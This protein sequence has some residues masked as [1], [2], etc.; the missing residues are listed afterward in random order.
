MNEN[1]DNEMKESRG[2]IADDIG[3]ASKDENHRRPK[4]SFAFKPQKKILIGGAG[5]LLLIILIALFSG[6][7]DELPPQDFRLNQLEEKITRLEGIRDTIVFLEKQGEELQQ[8]VAEARKSARSLTL[9]LDKLSQNVD[10]LQKGVAPLPGKT[11]APLAIQRKTF[12]L[13]K[14]RYHEVRRGDSL[15]RIALQYGTSVD[16][17][18]RLNN[19]SRNQVIYPG[20]RLLV[21]PE[22]N[23]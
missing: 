17:L 19:M 21:A 8:S 20:Q 2:K 18:C 15:Y 16:E 7:G 1:L 9:R 13:A 14:G 5:I 6:R 23:Q 12:P 11:K 10:R 22:G 3:Y 4:A